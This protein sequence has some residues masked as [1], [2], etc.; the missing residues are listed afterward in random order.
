MTGCNEWQYA[1]F[2]SMWRLNEF[3]LV[4]HLVVI[5]ITIMKWFDITVFFRSFHDWLPGPIPESLGQLTKL[6]QLSL[7]GNNLSGKRSSR[8][9]WFWFNSMLQDLHLWYTSFY[10][11]T[12]WSILPN[13]L[14]LMLGKMSCRYIFSRYICIIFLFLTQISWLKQREFGQLV[15]LHNFFSIPCIFL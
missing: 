9:V 7:C 3:R 6:A 14:R 12:I 8:I 2:C 4:W 11:Y 5:T 10:A 1:M 15:L 13:L